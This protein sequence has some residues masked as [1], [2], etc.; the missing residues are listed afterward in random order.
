MAKISQSMLLLIGSAATLSAFNLLW[1]SFPH[2]V[3]PIL[4]ILV[5][6]G[7][8]LVFLWSLLRVA[9]M[10]VPAGRGQFGQS[11]TPRSL[12]GLVVSLLLAN[13]LAV[14][15]C[16]FQW[17]FS[18]AAVNLLVPIAWYVGRRTMFAVMR[19]IQNRCL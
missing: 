13:A 3:H 15:L 12:L 19:R 16:G 10:S 6:V 14:H 7:V 9:L 17:C 18:I 11:I 1:L 8:G 4:P 2:S 5:N